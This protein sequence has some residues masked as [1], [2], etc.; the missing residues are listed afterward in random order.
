MRPSGNI[1]FS[2]VWLKSFSQQVWLCSSSGNKLCRYGASSAAHTHINLLTHMSTLQAEQ[3]FVCEA[4]AQTINDEAVCFD[5][6]WYST[7]IRKRRRENI[8]SSS[9]HN[10]TH[11]C[12]F[13]KKSKQMSH[14]M[15]PE[16]RLDQRSSCTLVFSFHHT[17]FFYY[18]L[19]GIL[20]FLLH[21]IHLTAVVSSQTK[22][23]RKKHMK[24]L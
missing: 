14:L 5:L 18:I 6:S 19:E 22:I 4:A 1:C 10:T 8:W 15:K 21:N 16:G 17:S 23:F 11:C 24:S 9:V 20:Y 12:H 3:I 13:R 2:G 7:L